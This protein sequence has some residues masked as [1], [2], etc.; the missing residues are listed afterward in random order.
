MNI[1]ITERDAVE[2]FDEFFNEVVPMVQI[3]TLEYEP[4]RVLK[5][6]DPVA[7]HQE[8]LAW[9]DQENLDVEGYERGT[10]K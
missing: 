6:V 2:R 5:E 10:L 9:L 1:K 4:A 8:F 7:Y 3:G